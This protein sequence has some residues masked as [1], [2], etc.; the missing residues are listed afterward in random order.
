MQLHFKRGGTY[1]LRNIK[2]KKI[3]DHIILIRFF[4]V[5]INLEGFWNYGQISLQVEDIYDILSVKFPHY[6]FLLLLDQ[7]SGHGKMRRGALNV[8]NMSLKFGGKQEKRGLQYQ[9]DW[10]LPCYL[11]DW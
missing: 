11:E 6:D 4:Y 3:V 5:G 9:R 8:H 2:K 10:T 7:S 1:Y